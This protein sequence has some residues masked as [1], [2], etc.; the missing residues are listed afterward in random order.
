ML[1]ACWHAI[2]EKKR[3]CYQEG[4]ARLIY[5]I[6]AMK[7]IFC[8]VLHS[9]SQN[10]TGN[11]HL[12]S[13]FEWPPVLV[14]RF[15]THTKQNGLHNHHYY[16]LY[17]YR[18]MPSSLHTDTLLSAVLF[19]LFPLPLA[20]FPIYFSFLKLCASTDIHNMNLNP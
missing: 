7:L 20:H 1:T 13:M 2:G 10:K 12:Q 11:V 18:P 5:C 16:W 4:S 8:V 19:H 17:S 3:N 15:N 9:P 14:L 6:K